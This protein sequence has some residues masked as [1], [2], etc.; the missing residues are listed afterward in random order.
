LKYFAASQ[1]RQAHRYEEAEKLLRGVLAQA[2]DLLGEEHFLVV[3]LRG[4]LAGLLRQ[5]GDLSGAEQEIRQA[6]EIGRRTVLRG[7]PLMIQALLELGD[8]E[9]ARGQSAEAEKLYREALDIAQRFDRPN[10]LPTIQTKLDD[11]LREHNH[12]REGE[13]K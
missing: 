9:R 11:L 3:I 7:H 10:L 2:G 12:P 1:A 6:L 4:D 8:F 5:K 13:G